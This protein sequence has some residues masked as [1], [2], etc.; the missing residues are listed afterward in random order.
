MIISKDDIIEI[1]EKD[2][3]EQLQYSAGSLLFLNR[4]TLKEVYE[5]VERVGLL[6]RAQRVGFKDLQFELDAPDVATQRITVFNKEKKPENLLFDMMIKI[7]KLVPKGEMKKFFGDDILNFIFLEWL[8]LQNPYV[9]FTKERPQLPGQ[10]YPG[11]HIKKELTILFRYLGRI[12]DLDG[13][14]AKPQFFHNAM[15]YMDY[16]KFIHGEKEGEFRAIY[17]KFIKEIG[18]AKL[19]WA[20]YEECIRY[21]FL[22]RR[23]IWKCDLQVYPLKKRVMDYF[24]SDIYK[25]AFESSYKK[26]FST[27]KLNSKCLETIKR[28][29]NLD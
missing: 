10:K 26:W 15:M 21:G 8:T 2:I 24:N 9:K 5:M 12:L 29:R 23:Y 1:S 27:V 28:V 11:L 18:F 17:D 7:E 22:K 16:F 19:S 14:I 13:Y 25:K 6:K 3:F 4:F 20:V